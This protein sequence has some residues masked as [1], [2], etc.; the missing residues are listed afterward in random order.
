[1]PTEVWLLGIIGLCLEIMG[2]EPLFAK[3]NLGHPLNM[4]IIFIIFLNIVMKLLSF[5]WNL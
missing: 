3:N 5:K 2:N 1:M 4:T